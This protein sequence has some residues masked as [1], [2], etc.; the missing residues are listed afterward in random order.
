MIED[1][2]KK[3][4]DWKKERKYRFLNYTKKRHLELLD[5]TGDEFNLDLLTHSVILI[6]HLNW[7]I[8]DQY[9]ELLEN[10]KQGKIDNYSFRTK[11]S[12]RYQSIEEVSHLLQSNRVLL[13]PDK[14]SVDF[15]NLLA[16]IENCCEAYSADPEP[17]RSEVEIGDVEFQI[18]MEKIYFEIQK[19]LK[20]E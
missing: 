10:Y 13:S 20:Q 11:F 2:K 8:R 16:E 12:K 14:N 3:Y 18:S 4:K 9:M 7:E 6:D 19:L 1:W 17:F 15:G 5:Q